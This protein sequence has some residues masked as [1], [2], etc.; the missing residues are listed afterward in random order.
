MNDN[1]TDD[2]LVDLII[3]IKKNNEL[4]EENNKLRKQLIKEEIK[5]EKGKKQQEHK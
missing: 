4:Q 2:L 5:Y 3:A 1:D